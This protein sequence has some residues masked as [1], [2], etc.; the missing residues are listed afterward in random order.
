MTSDKSPN[1]QIAGSPDA[2]RIIFITSD[3]RSGSTLLDLCLGQLA[4]C[5]SAGELRYLWER[6]LVQNQ[7]CGDGM[8]FREHPLWSAIVQRAFGDVGD[9]R[10]RQLLDVQCRVDHP[11]SVF[12]NA[13]FSPKRWLPS[14]KRDRAAYIEQLHKLY[15]SI[16]AETGARYIIDS[17]KA[18]S[19]GFLLCDMPETEVHVIHLVRD[20]RAVAF[21]MQRIK[22]RPEVEGE[23]YLPTYPP[24]NTALRWRLT[25]KVARRFRYH[26]ASYNTLRY[27]DLV[28][29][30]RLTI[31]TLIESLDLHDKSLDFIQGHTVTLQPNQTVAGNPMRFTQGELELKRDEQWRTAMTARDRRTVERWAGREL[32]R[33][34]YD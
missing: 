23:A 15:V 34:G 19:H 21:S 11:R 10:A 4:G 2:T 27:E 7:K 16:M 13:F 22:R 28:T 32:H 25:N 8:N 18:P 1:H 12:R 31:A 29:Q 3:S 9:E 30:P 24:M 6:G 26:A 5:F 17:S 14:F 33:C 20:A